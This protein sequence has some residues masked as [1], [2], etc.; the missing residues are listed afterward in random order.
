MHS[1]TKGLQE[2]KLNDLGKGAGAGK[3]LKD[4]D[5]A[6]HQQGISLG[7]EKRVAHHVDFPDA[8]HK[9]GSP[10]KT[11]DNKVIGGSAKKDVI[12]NNTHAEKLK[13]AVLAK[14][15]TKINQGPSGDVGFAKNPDRKAERKKVAA[16][17]KAAKT[18][19]RNPFTRNEGKS[20]EMFMG[21]CLTADD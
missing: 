15:K 19:K 9:D 10:A 12:S 6:A 1:H 17:N 16:A 21:D 8:R 14:H 5:K 7:K 3:K 2:I 13:Q 20:F 18:K 4:L 11:G